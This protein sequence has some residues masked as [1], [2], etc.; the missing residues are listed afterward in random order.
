MVLKTIILAV[1]TNAMSITRKEKGPWSTP[2]FRDQEDEEKAVQSN[3]K[4][5]TVN[6]K[7]VF[8]KPE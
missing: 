6:P 8:W 1:I 7:R 2:K 5:F 4:D 3:E